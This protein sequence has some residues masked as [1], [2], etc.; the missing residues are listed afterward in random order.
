MASYPKKRRVVRDPSRLRQIVGNDDNRV[1]ASQAADQVFDYTRGNWIKRAAGFIHQQNPWIQGQR[2][3]NA[4]TLL[5][6]A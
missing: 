2:A 3:G 6:P 4:K 5:L 1:A